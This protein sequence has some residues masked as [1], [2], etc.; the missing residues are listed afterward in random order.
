[1]NNKILIITAT[2][3]VMVGL[4]VGSLFGIF[5]TRTTPMGGLVH[6]V[7]ETFDEGIA[8]DGTTIIDGDGAI[9]STTGTFSS[10]L[11][12][13]GETNL[14]TLI[15]GG[16]IIATD[17]PS[18][19]LTAAQ[20]CNTAYFRIDPGGSGI[21]WTF[22][23]AAELIAD[24][25]P[26]TGDSKILYFENI[27]DAS[28]AITVDSGADGSTYFWGTTTVGQNQIARL[29]ISILS[30]ASASIIMTVFSK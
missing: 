2:I 22:P 9:T 4:I 17:T 29:D 7:L 28:E 20:V 21:T 18:V 8:V 12:I 16:D 5:L 6:N 23:T 11:T 19:S 24:C 25:L 10:T 13:I 30:A 3:C 15:F 26:T 1:M 27:A 14:D